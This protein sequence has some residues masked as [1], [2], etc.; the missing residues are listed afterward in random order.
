MKS[1]ADDLRLESM[2]A[3][4]EMTPARRI[5]LAHKLG[6]DDVAL[7][8]ATHGVSEAEARAAFRRAHAIGRIPSAS[9]DFDRS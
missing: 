4:A 9:N 1:V 8:R 7:Y 3:L 2:R 5:A 6:D